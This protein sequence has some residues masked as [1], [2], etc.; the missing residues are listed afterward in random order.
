M[1]DD[2]VD[3][4]LDMFALSDDE[5]QA[6]NKK[7]TK[8]VR[9]PKQR[10]AKTRLLNITKG[11]PISDAA[12]NNTAN[13]ASNWDDSEGYLRTILGETLDDRYQIFALLGKG[14]FASVVRARDLRDNGRQVA[15][16][17]IRVQ[18]TMYKAGLKEVGIL[19]KLN[20]SDPDDRKHVVR[21]ERHFDC[22]GHL[23]MVFESLSM[24]L[25]DVVR[26]YGRDVGL[27]LQAVRAYAHQLF[28]ALSHLVKNSVIHADIKPDNMLINDTK[29]LLKLCDL[30]RRPPSVRWKSRPT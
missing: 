20:E 7:K 2:E 8:V 19:H 12:S 17:I 25:R 22:K 27:N 3:A 21:L 4:E 26:R 29:T 14:M 15:I 16:K 6:T 13:L 11:L 1:T 18:E 24:N 23:C 28:L 9:V 5:G 10:D 30:A